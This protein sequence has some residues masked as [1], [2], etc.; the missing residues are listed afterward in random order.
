[1]TDCV[2]METKTC[3]FGYGG[4]DVSLVGRMIAFKGIKPP[5]GAGTQIWNKDGNKI[6]D[7]EFTGHDLCILFN[8]IDEI[9]DMFNALKEIEECKHGSFT[10]KDV[11][12]NFVEYK[13]VS[14]DIVKQAMHYV[15]RNMI[16]LTAC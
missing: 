11:T 6:G 12:L 10:I 14:M 5:L 4:I 13:Q 2:N 8:T 7:W 1:M 9:N 3:F 15:K 16:L